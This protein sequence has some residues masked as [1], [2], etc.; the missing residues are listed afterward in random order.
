MPFCKKKCNYCDFCSEAAGEEKIGRYVDALCSEIKEFTGD[1]RIA[2][3][4]VF[5]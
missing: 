4:T 3:D 2:A 5:W 1:R